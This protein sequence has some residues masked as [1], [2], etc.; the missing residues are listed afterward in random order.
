MRVISFSHIV[1]VLFLANAQS[2]LAQSNLELPVDADNCAIHHALSPETSGDCG[3]RSNGLSRGIVL[4]IDDALKSSSTGQTTSGTVT[5]QQP[6]APTVR[7]A[8]A[9]PLIT[10]RTDTTSPRSNRGA[11]KSEDGYFVHFAFD[12]AQLESQFQAHLDRLSDVLKVQAMASACLK[13]VGHTDTVG[14]ATYNLK[15]SERRA[16]TVAAY[17]TGTKGIPADRVATEA[18]GETRPL[19]EVMGDD[20][21][22]RRVEFATKESLEGC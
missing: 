17:L 10:T 20:A 21:R 13:I 3:I 18:A 6:I 11:A 5:P 4:R 16:Q 15:L 14:D 22:N 2:T 19:P 9:S 1:V 8:A 12:S 7:V